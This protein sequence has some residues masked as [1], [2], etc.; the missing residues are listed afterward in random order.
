MSLADLHVLVAEDVNS[1]RFQIRDVLKECGFRKITLATSGE[2]AKACIMSEA[3]SLV[4]CD[5]YM[6]PT[7]G[8]EVLRMVR[9]TEQLKH[10]AFIMVTGESTK[11]RVID[12]IQAGVDDYLVKPLTM[13]QVQ[14]RV[15]QIL[16]RRKMI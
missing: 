13:I 3:P 14:S 11:E 10:I 7:D 9:S 1:T 2:E 15:L 6:S 16:T 5:W 8:F 4:L 12:A